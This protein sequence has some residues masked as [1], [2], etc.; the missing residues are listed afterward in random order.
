MGAYGFRDA[1][2]L[3][4]NWCSE[5]YMGLN[6]APIV[7]MIENYRTGLLWKLFMKNPEVQNGLKN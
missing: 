6:Q 7:V 5:I 1:F 4:Q 2:N 3:H